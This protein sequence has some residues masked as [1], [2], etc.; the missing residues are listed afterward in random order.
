MP[1]LADAHRRPTAL[2]SMI[3]G[4]ALVIAGGL[5]AAVTS[6]LGLP[7]G[8]WLAAYLVLVGGVPQYIVGRAAV[9]WRRERTGWSVLA[10]WNVGNAAVIAGSLLS[11]PYLV[12]A[13]G[14]LLIAAL[15]ALLGAVWRR[16]TPGIPAL[17]TGAWRWLVIAALAILIASVPVGLVLA[18]LRAG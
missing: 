1:R 3:L 18:H 6:P 15:V 4:G 10:L 8:S 14:V 16:Q 11:Q 13:G 12:D 17:T 2:W 7:K 9:A 5:V